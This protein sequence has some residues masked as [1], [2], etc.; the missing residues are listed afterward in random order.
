VT[1]WNDLSDAERD[2][3]NEEAYCEC[4]DKLRAM[5]RNT[6]GLELADYQRHV[7][8]Q[9][10]ADMRENDRLIKRAQRARATQWDKRSA[11]YAARQNEGLSLQLGFI[12]DAE[13]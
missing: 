9:L 6:P 7:E 10:V 3:L 11:D 12:W 2:A 8:A 13:I 1:N 4:C 5:A